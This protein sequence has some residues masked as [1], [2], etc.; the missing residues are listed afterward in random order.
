MLMRSR[1]LGLTFLN[2]SAILYPISISRFCAVFASRIFNN[3][4]YVFSIGMSSSTP[5][6]FPRRA[7]FAGT[8]RRAG[9]S[10]AWSEEQFEHGYIIP[11]ILLRHE[12]EK[13]AGFSNREDALLRNPQFHQGNSEGA[14]R[15]CLPKMA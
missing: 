11:Q 9:P 10:R 1:D 13:P 2:E 7:P 8:G 5:S 4:T 14:G 15:I 6:E 12:S 3:L